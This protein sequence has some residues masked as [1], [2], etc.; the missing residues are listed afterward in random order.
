MVSTPTSEQIRKKSRSK[1]PK[2]FWSFFFSSA[3][4]VVSIL[5]AE[6]ARSTLNVNFPYDSCLIARNP[7]GPGDS[8]GSLAGFLLARPEEAQAAHG[9]A[10]RAGGGLA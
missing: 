1:R 6:T 5:A 8:P 4:S 2:C 7:A 9:G 3:A 10:N